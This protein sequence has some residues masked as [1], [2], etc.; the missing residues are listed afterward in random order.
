MMKQV[1]AEVEAKM[2]RSVGLNLNLNLNLGSTH[3]PCHMKST[4]V[5]SRSARPIPMF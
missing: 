2:L 3:F 5:P 4:S 1:E